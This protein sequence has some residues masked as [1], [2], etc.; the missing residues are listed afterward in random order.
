MTGRRLYDA[1]CDAWAREGSFPRS[2]SKILAEVPRAWP[3]L[4]AADRATF[5]AAARALTPKPRRK[6]S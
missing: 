3:F 4:T 2:Q 1:L 6:Q 5:N